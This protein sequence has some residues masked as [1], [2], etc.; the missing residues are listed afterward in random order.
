MP[1]G[2]PAPL[3]SQLSQSPGDLRID[4]RQEVVRQGAP[5]DGKD[6]DSAY[7]ELLG[8]SSQEIKALAD[9]DVI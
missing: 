7:G 6:S 5:C 2:G 1:T 4:G 3:A 8:M 9:E